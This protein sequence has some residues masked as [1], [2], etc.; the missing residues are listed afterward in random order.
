MYLTNAAIN[1][2]GENYKTPRGPRSN[3]QKSNIGNGEYVY[4]YN[5]NI[6]P[7]M[8]CINAPSGCKDPVTGCCFAIKNEKKR[9]WI[10]KSTSSNYNASKQPNFV[11]NMVAEI[12]KLYLKGTNNKKNTPFK[13]YI[14]I[15]GSGDYYDEDYFWKW[16]EIT[17]QFKN[18]TEFKN[19][20]FMSY[21]K[22]IIM[23]NNALSDKSMTLD[24]INIKIVFSILKGFASGSNTEDALQ[25][26]QY[27][28]NLMKSSSLTAIETVKTLKP[29]INSCANKLDTYTVL[30][31]GT[32]INQTCKLKCIDCQWCYNMH[33]VAGNKDIIEF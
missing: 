15:H 33:S 26:N 23:I 8:T 2:I 30:K 9:D 20:H 13:I 4:F 22:E 27:L 17:N 32:N 3:G 21:T 28:N 1:Q 5:F 25:K 11:Q 19:L 6:T 14:R 12:K 24:D 10:R 29:F 31:K 18:K 16:V 7:G